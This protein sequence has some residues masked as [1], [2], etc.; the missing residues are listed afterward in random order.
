MSNNIK[1]VT[2][3]G[4][5]SNK[6]INRSYITQQHSSKLFNYRKEKLIR[7][8]S[9]SENCAPSESTMSGACVVAAYD[10]TG[11]LCFIY[12]IYVQVIL[13]V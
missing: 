7:G 8:A 2:Y 13:R 4:V 9:E 6:T 12:H 10:Y 3:G 5:S 1:P 11:C